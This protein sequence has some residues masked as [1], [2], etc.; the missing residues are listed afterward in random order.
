MVGF[1]K[2]VLSVRQFAALEPS[3]NMI[4]VVRTPSKSAGIKGLP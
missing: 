3:P 2:P 4:S 1:L